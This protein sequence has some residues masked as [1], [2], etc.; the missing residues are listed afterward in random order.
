HIR[1]MVG[2][3][4]GA[5]GSGQNRGHVQNAHARQG[6]AVVWYC[7]QLN[8]SVLQALVDGVLPECRPSHNEHFAQRNSLPDSLTSVFRQTI[9]TTNTR[10]PRTM[11]SIHLPGL[12]NPHDLSAD[13]QFS[14]NLARGM[15]V[16]RAFTLADSL[17][18]NREISD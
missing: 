7:V 11:P 15:E 13:R 2:A 4:G 9:M 14:M 10:K 5:K 17:L 1:A 16:L 18:G 6:A 12:V 8:I 3:Q